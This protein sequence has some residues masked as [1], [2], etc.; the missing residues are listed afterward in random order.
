MAIGP[1]MTAPY[2]G[3][4]NPTRFVTSWILPP[5]V[6]FG[7]RALLALYAFATLFT[8]FGWNG[9]HG[10]SAESQRSFSFFTVLTYWGL[11]FYYAFSAVHTGS[12]WLTGE[13]F[14]ARWPKAAQIAHSMFYS[15]IVVYPWLVTIVYWGLLA[16]RFP[17]TFALWSNTSQH[18]L[19]SAYAFFE[20]FFPR[21]ERL[22]WLSLIPVILLLAL[23][24]GLAYLT[25]ATQGFYVY[26]FL[27]LQTHSSGVVAG[28]ILGILIAA[29]I[30]FLIVRYLI[31]LR[32]WVTETK[33]GKKGEFSTHSKN[34][35]EI[36]G[37]PLQSTPK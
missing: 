8:I 10:R 23:Y 3:P 27:D 30:I 11:A 32:V 33:L 21:T 14:L 15:T 35:E 6:L 34:S 13:A 25:H 17:T 7:I 28:Y 26:P 20:I 19:N 2:T 31:A 9:A 18:A 5:G 36:D 12:Y 24:L 22:P 16:S 4:F 29:I 1:R 37:F